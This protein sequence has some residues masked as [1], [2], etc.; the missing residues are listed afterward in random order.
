MY[1][2]AFDTKDLMRGGRYLRVMNWKY[3]DK[4]AAIKRAQEEV[5]SQRP[6]INVQV[7][8]VPDG[9]GWEEAKEHG[10]VVYSK[11]GEKRRVEG[12]WG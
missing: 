5:N 1:F 6:H 4:E 2:I 12:P 9:E 7:L 11:E 10:K 3:E 8:E